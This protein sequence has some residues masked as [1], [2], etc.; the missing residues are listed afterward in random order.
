LKDL[1]KEEQDNHYDQHIEDWQKEKYNIGE[2][3]ILLTHWVAKAWKRLHL[4]YKDT[5]VKTFWSLRIALNPNGSK[6]AELKVKGIPD[7]AVGN[8]Q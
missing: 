6:D 3:R 5:I 8:Y 2:R 4:E 1:I 7:I